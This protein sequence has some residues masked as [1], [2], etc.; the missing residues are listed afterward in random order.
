MTTASSH[1]QQDSGASAPRAD[2]PARI[3]VQLWP[4]GTPDFGTWRRAVS[5]PT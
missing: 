2:R 5:A 4:G 1:T 3:G